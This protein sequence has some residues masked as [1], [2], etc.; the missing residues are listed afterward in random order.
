LSDFWESWLREARSGTGILRG[1]S[2]VW[3]PVHSSCGRLSTD[4]SRLLRNCHELCIVR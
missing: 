3:R 2:D 1:K 4:W